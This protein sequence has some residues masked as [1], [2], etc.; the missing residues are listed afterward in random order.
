MISCRVHL[1]KPEP[2]IYR[3]LIKQYGLKKTQTIFIDDLAA[4]LEPAE[5]IGMTDHKVRKSNSM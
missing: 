5:R 2:E 4:N 1:I 3:Y